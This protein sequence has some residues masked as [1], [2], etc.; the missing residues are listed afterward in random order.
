MFAIVPIRPLQED[1]GFW[2]AFHQLG[3]ELKR[4]YE[5]DAAAVSWEDTK[6]R[7]VSRIQLE[8]GFFPAAVYREIKLVGWAYCRLANAGTP[9]Q[10]VGVSFNALFDRIPAALK[11]ELA[12]W[13]MGRL[14]QTGAERFYYMTWDRREIEVIENWQGLE[15]SRTDEYELSLTEADREVITSW[16][17]EA[18]EANPDLRSEPFE[19][20]P[21]H[22]WDD[23]IRLEQQAVEDMPEERDSGQ[24]TRVDSEELRKDIEW[25]RRHGIVGRYVFLL[26]S[27]QRLLGLTECSVN[28]NK[29]E[30]IVQ[31]MTVVRREYRGRGLAKWLKASMFREMT[32]EFPHCPKLATWMRSINE[33]IQ[34]INKQMGYRL[35]RTNREFK[36]PREGVEAFL[37]Q[38]AG[39]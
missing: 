14:K 12:R 10:V 16:E 2:R 34:H 37:Q 26:D 4:R 15:F 35:K 22:L 21:E 23:F 6:S 5:A 39:Q 30:R 32:N 24:S 11:Q 8:P 28:L 3:L 25:R 27:R 36:V 31:L 1:D 20:I 9:D 29:M 19:E 7:H 17:R 18:L 38:S 33:P 13:V